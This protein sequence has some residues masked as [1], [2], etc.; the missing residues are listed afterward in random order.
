MISTVLI[1]L[2]YALSSKK[3]YRW[4]SSYNEELERRVEVLS[5]G[6]RDSILVHFKKLMGWNIRL[7]DLETVN[8]SLSWLLLIGILVYAIVAIIESGVTAHGKVL[9]ILMYVFSYIES[10]IAMPLFYQQYVRLKEITHRLEGEL[11]ESSW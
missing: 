2:I 3:I 4:N 11:G 9:S 6:D 10:V 5:N 8:F 7:S 1:I